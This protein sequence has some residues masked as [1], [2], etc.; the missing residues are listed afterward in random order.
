MT[1]F[2]KSFSSFP[3]SALS[4]PDVFL[5][6][7]PALQAALLKPSLFFFRPGTL[8]LPRHSIMSN[9]FPACPRSSQLNISSRC[10]NQSNSQ[11]DCQTSNFLLGRLS[12]APSK[13]SHSI[14]SFLRNSK[15]RPRNHSSSPPRSQNHRDLHAVQPL[16][17]SRPY[18]LNRHV[19]EAF[20]V[21]ETSGLQSKLSSP[22]QLPADRSRH[23]S[24]SRNEHSPSHHSISVR[25]RRSD[26]LH[27]R[28]DSGSLPILPESRDSVLQSHRP[29]RIQL[30][31]PLPL[32][33]PLHLSNQPADSPLHTG[34]SSRRLLQPTT[35]SP[36]MAQDRLYSRIPAQ[37]F[38]DQAGILGPRP[39]SLDPKRPAPKPSK[40]QPLPL[41]PLHT[42]HLK[43]K[44]SP[45]GSSSTHIRRPFSPSFPSRSVLN[46]QGPGL[47]GAPPSHIPSPTSPPSSRPDHSLQRSVHLHQG[48]SNAPDFRSRRI[49]SHPKQQARIRLGDSECLGQSPNIRS[50]KRMPPSRRRLLLLS[51]SIQAPT[52]AVAA[53]LANLRPLCRPC[54]GSLPPHPTSFQHQPSVLTALPPKYS[55]PSDPSQLHFGSFLPSPSISKEARVHSTPSTTSTP[56]STYSPAP[57]PTAS[58]SPDFPGV[59]ASPTHASPNHPFPS[60]NSAPRVITLFPPQLDSLPPTSSHSTTDARPVSPSSPSTPISPH[61]DA[62]GSRS[63]DNF[64]LPP[65]CSSA[66]SDSDSSYHSSN[67]Y[68][69][70]PPRTIDP[71]SIAFIKARAFARLSTLLTECPYDSE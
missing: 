42:F 22:R 34:G 49:R 46:L 24:L 17:L 35:P 26:V 16:E 10:L 69:R 12:L 56:Q 62:S 25:S 40:P 71:G 48:S 14:P 45:T 53:A 15:L 7:I 54:F 18:P 11:F 29:S 59:Q 63:S 61:L 28:P 60:P 9:V 65:V 2:S 27:P 68:P 32:P 36:L 4:S 44:K 30:H 66:D 51:K 31:R 5:F 20:K 13:R 50:V 67:S 70:F 23:C 55:P 38:R 8:P 52:P 19:H 47:L 57:P 39:L 1:L 37:P 64:S 43:K 6:S 21:P 58:T 33:K 3:S 41:A